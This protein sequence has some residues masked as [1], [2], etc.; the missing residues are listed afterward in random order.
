MDLLR[1]MQKISKREKKFEKKLDAKLEKLE[2]KTKK[3]MEKKSHGLFGDSKS[4]SKRRS[5]LL[6]LAPNVGPSAP[7]EQTTDAPFEPKQ[8]SESRRRTKL[9][10]MGAGVGP[11]ALGEQGMDALPVDEYN[12]IPHV[13]RGEVVTQNWEVL[14]NGQMPWTNEVRI[15]PLTVTDS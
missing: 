4:E 8:P 13:Q 2:S 11:V 12:Y 10:V 1:H 3:I 9:M 5:K 6:V 15:F 7:A 14:N